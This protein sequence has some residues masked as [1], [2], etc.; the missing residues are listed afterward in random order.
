MFKKGTDKIFGLCRSVQNDGT[1]EE[2][3]YIDSKKEGLGRQIWQNGDMYI[4]C[5]KENQYHGQGMKC[6]ANGNIQAVEYF[7]GKVIN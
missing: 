4:G 1:I 3:A 6:H 5:F 7:N 2:A